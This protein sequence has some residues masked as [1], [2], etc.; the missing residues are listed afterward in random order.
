MFFLPLRGS[1]PVPATDGRRRG[2]P[3]SPDRWFC[4]SPIGSARN[5][6]GTPPL[7]VQG[8]GRGGAPAALRAKPWALTWRV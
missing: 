6:S 2:P 1:G 3:T 4:H 8:E 7:R 5:D